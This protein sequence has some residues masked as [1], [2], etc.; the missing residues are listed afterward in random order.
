MP[1][2]TQPIP[3]SVPAAVKH[4]LQQ[5]PSI[6]CLGYVVPNPSHGMKHHVQTGR[7][8]LFLQKPATLIQKNFK[9]LKWNSNVWNPLALFVVQHHHGHPFQLMA[10]PSIWKNVF[11][12]FQLWNFSVTRF[13]RRVWPLW[14]NIPPQSTLVQPSGYQAAAKISRYGKL[15]PL[16]PSW[17]CPH[18]VPLTDL[19]KSSL[20]TLDWNAG[21]EEAFEDVKCIQTK[22]VPLQHPS[23]Q[24]ELS[25]ATY[26]SDSQIPTMEASCSKNPVTIGIGFFSCKLPDMEFVIP[27][28]TRSC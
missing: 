23:L 15:L 24:A 20:K 21:S 18:F 10:L 5:F 1:K 14:P 13:Q 16:F 8:S 26:A 9:L 27:C 28:S 25:V 19:L 6:L 22:V 11:L 4:L 3:D 12:L 7:P 2:P 17:L